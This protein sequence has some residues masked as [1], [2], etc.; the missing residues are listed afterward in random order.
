[1]DQAIVFGKYDHLL[2]ITNIPIDKDQ[3]SQPQ[4]VAVILVT[5]GMLN[6]VGPFRMYVDIANKLATESIPSLRFDLSGIGESLGV[7]VSGRSIDRAAEEIIEAMD[8]LSAKHD[9]DKFILFGLC[10]GADDSFQTALK[11]PRVKGIIALDGVAYK[12]R[13]FKIK[14][15][16]RYLKLL[17]RW[18]KWLNKF[19]H[20]TST[21]P[22]PAS[23]ASGGDV[24]EFPATSDLATIEFQQLVDQ[25]I[26]MHFIYTGGTDYYNY[27]QQFYDMLPE[28]NWGKTESTTFFPHMDH[29]VL[30]CEDRQELVEHVTEKSKLMIVGCRSI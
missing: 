24:R 17:M 18:D 5:A 14:K 11:D 20:L 10:S 28:V 6:S 7:G 22:A 21:Q 19:R 16:H 2:G 29:V 12:T 8:Y 26:Q 13:K 9:I 15:L 3:Q 25:G 23:L 1:M 30:L 4:S 27:E